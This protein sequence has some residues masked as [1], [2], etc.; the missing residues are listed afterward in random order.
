MHSLRAGNPYNAPRAQGQVFAVNPI[1]PGDIYG[2]LD[3][4]DV[5]MFVTVLLGQDSTA[6]HIAR[7]DLNH[8]SAADGRDVQPFVLTIL[9][10]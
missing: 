9:G 6:S 5:Q 7:A 4:T 8:D 2:D 1:Q 10:L 3:S